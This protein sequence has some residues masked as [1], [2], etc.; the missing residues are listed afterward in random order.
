INI[1]S[2]PSP[3]P[4]DKKNSGFLSMG[5]SQDNVKALEI[6]DINDMKHGA[7]TAALIEIYKNNLSSLPLSSL[8]NKMRDLMAQEHYFQGPGFHFDSTRL[9]FPLITAKS[10][11]VEKNRARCIAIKNGLIKLDRGTLSGICQGNKLTA[12]NI[13]GKPVIEII[14][15]YPDS[16]IAKD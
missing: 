16:S 10:G 9:K 8:L 14:T 7:F 13:P 3:R 4:Y 2:K 12:I 5:A 15:S 1:F 6:R 11:F